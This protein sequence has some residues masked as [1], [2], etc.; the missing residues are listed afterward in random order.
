MTKSLSERIGL[1]AVKRKSTGKQFLPAYIA[2]KPEIE[3][4][5]KDD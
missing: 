2:L 1:H 4:A 5:L 3:Q